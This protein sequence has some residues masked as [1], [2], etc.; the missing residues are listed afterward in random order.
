MK[1]CHLR[2]LIAL[3]MLTALA[4]CVQSYIP[5]A[6]HANNNYLVVDGFLNSG[7]DST[8]ITLSR[9]QNLSASNVFVP[10]LHAQVSVLSGNLIS[11]P[12]TEQGNGI[13]WSSGLNL[14]YNQQY[15]LKI[16]TSDGKEYLSDSVTPKLTPP[17]DSVYWQQ[18]N[19]G[20]NIDLD[21]HDPQNNTRYYLW[22]FTETWQ[23]ET[24]F[25]SSLQFDASGQLVPRPPANQVHTCWATLNSTNVLT[26]TTSTLEQD[27]VSKQPITQV[28]AN[29]EQIFILFSI[30]VRQYAISRQAF[31][32]WQ[33]LITSTEQLGILFGPQPTQVTGNIHCVSNPA[34]P[35]LGYLSAR[36]QSE[37]RIFINRYQLGLWLMPTPPC[38]PILLNQSQLAQAF[39]DSVLTIF[40]SEAGPGKWVFSSPSC[41]DC[42]YDHGGVTTKPSFWP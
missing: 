30:L 13:Y 11:I 14:N 32:Y 27:I 20:V 41:S 2:I 40:I 7:P 17:I 23:D 31:Q 12:I 6:I 19:S 21:T 38:Y 34:E 22:N 37:A 3:W 18:I 42:R 29:S 25:T 36:S 24:F 9:A 39:S 35:V 16:I 5:P 15:L 26:A 4:A 1:N 33:N 28:P 8:V 10:E